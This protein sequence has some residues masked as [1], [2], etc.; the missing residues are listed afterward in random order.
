MSILLKGIHIKQKNLYL[1]MKKTQKFP[2]II[3]LKELAQNFEIIISCVGN[4]KDCQ[5]FI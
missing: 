4:D 5:R 2:F 1:N 3:I